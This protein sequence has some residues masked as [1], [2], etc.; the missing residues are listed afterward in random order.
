MGAQYSDPISEIL[1]DSPE[2]AVGTSLKR[3]GNIP[4]LAC[5]GR[6]YLRKTSSG[7]T[8]YV[9]FMGREPTSKSYHVILTDD[10]PSWD[11]L[12]VKGDVAAIG[13]TANSV[14]SALALGGLYNR[15][16]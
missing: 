10:I 8:I 1:I 3:I 5:Y 14:L 6:L 16:A 11:G 12:L 15:G 13:T 4:D 2:V 9:A 7:D